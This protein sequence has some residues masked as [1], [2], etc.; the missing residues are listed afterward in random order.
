M[1]LFCNYCNRVCDERCD[2]CRY[3]D[4]ATLME[5]TWENDEPLNEEVKD[6]KQN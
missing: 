1:T 3:R 4:E 6:E 2:L 5:P